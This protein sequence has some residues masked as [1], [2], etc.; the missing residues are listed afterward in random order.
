VRKVQNHFEGVTDRSLNVLSQSKDELDQLSKSILG[1][2]IELQSSQRLADGEGLPGSNTS[3][4]AL[5]GKMD[6]D[7]ISRRRWTP[8]LY[9]FRTELIPALLAPSLYE[10]LQSLVKVALQLLQTLYPL[11]DRSFVHSASKLYDLESAFHD[12]NRIRRWKKHGAKRITL[13]MQHLLAIDV[14][15]AGTL[16]KAFV[17]FGED[18]E[19]W[20]AW[21]S[22]TH[23]NPSNDSERREQQ[24]E[25]KTT[26]ESRPVCSDASSNLS[27]PDLEKGLNHKRATQ[28]LK[29]GLATVATIHAAHCLYNSMMAA[30]KRRKMVLDGEMSPEEATERRARNILQDAS[31]LGLVALS[32]TSAYSARSGTAKGSKERDE[33]EVRRCRLRKSHGRRED[34]RKRQPAHGDSN[35]YRVYF[36]DQVADSQG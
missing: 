24:T 34:A 10:F 23:P 12:L 31:E 8:Y 6:E 20:D 35:P 1:Y 17:A 9:T 15:A 32:I 5:F 29:A 7:L 21:Y 26:G 27:A 13:E 16:Q 36:G 4:L 2:F 28:V 33:L 11:V 3:I 30:K 22:K 18:F 14:S 25:P 19:S